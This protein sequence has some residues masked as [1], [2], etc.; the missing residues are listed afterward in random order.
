VKTRPNISCPASV[1]TF[2]VAERMTLYTVNASTFGILGERV[3][4]QRRVSSTHF[5][6]AVFFA[7]A[8]G[9]AAATAGGC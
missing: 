6:I 2:I 5:E 4:A 1:L 8:T 3:C 9:R 7:W